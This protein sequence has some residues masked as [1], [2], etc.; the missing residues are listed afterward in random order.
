M[1]RGKIKGPRN[2]EPLHLPY[3]G[4]SERGQSTPER[5]RPLS[6]ERTTQNTQQGAAQSSRAGHP[7]W[8]AMRARG[9]YDNSR[10]SYKHPH[11]SAHRDKISLTGKHWTTKG[12]KPSNSLLARDTTRDTQLYSDNLSETSKNGNI[13]F[14]T[15]SRVVHLLGQSHVTKGGHMECQHC[16]KTAGRMEAFSSLC[17]Q[18]ICTEN[19][20]CTAPQGPPTP[21][22]GK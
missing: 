14:K 1:P 20:T 6:A 9:E 12:L 13:I 18:G 22:P 8:P 19:R 7:S 15:D 11:M 17:I 16:G 2:R 3:T 4:W 10:Q 5:L 21:A